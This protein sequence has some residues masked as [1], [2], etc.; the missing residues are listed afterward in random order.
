MTE[1]HPGYEWEKGKP[2]RRVELEDIPVDLDK[3]PEI[4]ND[5]NARKGLVKRLKDQQDMRHDKIK[6]LIEILKTKHHGKRE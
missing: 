5:N 3:M 6:D 4:K 2:P 1:T